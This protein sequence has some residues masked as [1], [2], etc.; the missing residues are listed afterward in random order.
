[1]ATGDDVLTIDMIQE[2]LNQM[3]KKEKEKVLGTYN[4]QYKQRCCKF[5]KYGYK[6]GD[7]KC[8]ENK[9]EKYEKK[10][11]R[12]KKKKFNGVCY[13]CRKEE[14]MGWDCREQKYSNYKNMR[15]QKKPLM[16]IRTI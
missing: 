7:Q 15:K 10:E 6:P 2:K 8:L 12:N 4:K 11:N 16:E 5:G 14:H 9:N 3:Y 1:M 13:H